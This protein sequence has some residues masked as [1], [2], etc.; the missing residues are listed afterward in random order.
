MAHSHKITMSRITESAIEQLAIEKLEA[1]GYQYVYGSAIAA[2]GEVPE[3]QLYQQVILPG[4]V[5]AA[6]KRINPGVLAVA[7]EQTF[8]TIARAGNPDLL[9][10]NETI[11][12]FLTNRVEVS[13]NSKDGERDDNAG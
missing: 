13:Y 3:R 9:L 5:K 12:N 8:N 10:S 6:I 4:K 2:D 7:I 1:L 11:H